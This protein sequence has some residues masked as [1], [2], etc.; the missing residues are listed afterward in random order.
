[1]NHGLTTDQ[2]KAAAS[3]GEV[4]ELLDKR[5][6]KV[7][8]DP[9]LSRKWFVERANKILY[10]IGEVNPGDYFLATGQQL[11]V[12]AL[13]AAARRADAQIVE[14]ITERISQ[15]VHQPDGS[16]KKIQVFKFLGFREFYKF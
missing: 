5:D 4:V 15:E 3:M 13:N 16:V 14:S 2:F 9:N 1:M 10:S 6:L 7:P 11:L 8:P 12:M